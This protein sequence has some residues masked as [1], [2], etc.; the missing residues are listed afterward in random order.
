VSSGRLGLAALYLGVN[1]PFVYKYVQRSGHDG[2]AACLAYAVFAIVLVGWGP[3][4]SATLARRT[5]AAG[6]WILVAI[7]AAALLAI[8]SRFDPAAIR[9]TR[10]PA[11][12]EWL[13]RLLSGRFPYASSTHPSSFPAW[14]LI[15]WPFRALGDVGWIQV[16]AFV[17]FAALCRSGSRDAP[18]RAW[19]AIALLLASPLFLYEVATRSELFANTTLVLAALLLVERA[20]SLPGRI[21]AGVVTGIALSTRG[22]AGLVCA[23]LFPWIFRRR[24]GEGV[25]A[26][27]IA[28]ATFAA[29]LLPFVLWDPAR[30]RSDGPFAIQSSYA[31]GWLLAALLAT[32]VVV[33]A[34][35][36]SA[37][38][39]WWSVALL[40]FAAVGSVF[41]YSIVTEGWNAVLLDDRFDISY[42]AFGQTAMLYA[43]ARFG[44]ESDRHGAAS[45]PAHA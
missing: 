8:Q 24:P 4:L 5:R 33:G 35:A 26:G 29:T 2:L 41:V 37:R 14:F 6:F 44:V 11:I 45:D 28:L 18:D 12:E 10:A 19:T 7:A 43:V 32:G 17:A 16:A 20:R 3:V 15:A 34:R 27:L 30:F 13:S 9:V 21:A 25:V 40:L 22:I 42:F 36:A 39:A 31:P 1:A 23:V 38:A